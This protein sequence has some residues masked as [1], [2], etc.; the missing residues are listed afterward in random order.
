MTSYYVM[1]TSDHLKILELLCTSSCVNLV[2]IAKTV[3][4]VT[5][6]G[7]GGGSGAPPP[8]GP[9]PPPPPRSQKVQKSPVRKGLS[10]YRKFQNKALLSKIVS[11]NGIKRPYVPN[12]HP[13][14]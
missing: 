10:Y 3:F 7:G 8:P 12:T 4:K 11:Q 5:W 2:T 1:M 9:P 14:G 6:G 13:I